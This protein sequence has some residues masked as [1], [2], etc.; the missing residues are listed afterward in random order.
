MAMQ[1]RVSLGKQDPRAGPCTKF[2]TDAFVGTHALANFNVGA[3]RL[4][5]GRHFVDEGNLGRQEVVDAYFTI[6]AEGTSITS[7]L[8]DRT[9]GS[10]NSVVVRVCASSTPRTTR[11]G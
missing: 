6:S 7:G 8:P 2:V 4:G 3:V 5:Q 11:S 10:Y 9:N 1:A